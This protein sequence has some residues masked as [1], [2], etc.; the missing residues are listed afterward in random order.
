M[1]VL[2]QQMLLGCLEYDELLP[3]WAK[4]MRVILAPPPLFASIKSA[5][6]EK[7][8]Q[9]IT[10]SSLSQQAGMKRIPCWTESPSCKVL[11]RPL[12]DIVQDHTCFMLI[13]FD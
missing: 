7:G 1:H 6:T 8:W 10:A 4:R 11:F 9:G 13:F 3:L 2:T 5:R 12:S